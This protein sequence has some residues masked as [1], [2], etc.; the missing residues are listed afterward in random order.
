MKKILLFALPLLAMIAVS[1]EK[2]NKTY[3]G[4]TKLVKEIYCNGN[5]ILEFQYDESKRVC[6]YNDI[7]SGE[8]DPIRQYKYEYSNDEIRIISDDI[9]RYRLDNQGYIVEIHVDDVRN[10]E[11]SWHSSYEY[12]NG[13]LTK[14]GEEFVFVWKNGNMYPSSLVS[15]KKS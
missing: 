11:D 6:S 15:G 8:P 13:N 1:C 2:D 3:S 14:L 5:I 7:I 10:P 9:Y 12:T 4:T